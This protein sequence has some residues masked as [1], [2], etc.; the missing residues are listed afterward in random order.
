MLVA[1]SSRG[2]CL[3]LCLRAL[4]GAVKMLKEEADKRMEDKGEAPP[5]ALR[6]MSERAR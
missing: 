2:P 5:K 4:L 1:A 3:C 6:D